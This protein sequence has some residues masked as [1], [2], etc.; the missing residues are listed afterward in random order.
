M[1]FA[2][3]FIKTYLG[4]SKV[5][6]YSNQVAVYQ[7]EGCYDL[8]VLSVPPIP[9]QSSKVHIDKLRS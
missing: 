2:L 7:T 3:M 4:Y 9:L 8:D 5:M 1:Y 6:F